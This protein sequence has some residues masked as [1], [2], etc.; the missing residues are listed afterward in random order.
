[1][2]KPIYIDVMSG[3][4]FIKQIPYF[5]SSSIIVNGNMEQVLD[6]QEISEYV[7]SKL[8][9]LKGQ[10]GIKIEFSSQRIINR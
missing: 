4:R 6:A 1:M 3:E 7:Y 8:P 2:N 9:Y 10:E 5:I